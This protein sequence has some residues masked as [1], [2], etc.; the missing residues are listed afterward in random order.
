M[1]MLLKVLNDVEIEWGEGGATS[2]SDDTLLSLMN[3]FLEH[4]KGLVVGVLGLATLTMVLLGLYLFF[5]LGAG[6]TNFA[7]KNIN[8]KR[9]VIWAICMALLGSLDLV[10]AL[11]YNSL[12]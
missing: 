12:R 3:N 8:M 6:S 9:F 4:Y 2:T 11:V 7:S 10:V 1:N 5:N